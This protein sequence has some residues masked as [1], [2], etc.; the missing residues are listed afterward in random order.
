M[1]A[2][3]H[4]QGMRVF[5][6]DNSSLK[7]AK[8]ILTFQSFPFNPPKRRRKLILCFITKTDH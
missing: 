7:L 3:G 5:F 6:F 1:L 8:E 2:I 4:G